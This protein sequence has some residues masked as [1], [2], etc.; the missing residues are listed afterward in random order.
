MKRVLLTGATGFIG[1]HCLPLL[2]EKG[3]EVYAVTSKL[4]VV[5]DDPR[6]HW[7]SS[8]L[9][10][11]GGVARL[12]RENSY[13]HLLHFAWFV[14]PG[15]C[16]TS[17][18]NFRWVETSLQLLRTFTEKGGR[19]AVF[20]GSCA[21]YDWRYG[22]CSER[23]TPLKPLSTYGICKK[24]LQEMFTE[25]TG[26]TGMS[27]AWGRIFFLYGPFEDSSRLV[28][29]VIF[30]LLQKKPA[31]CSHCRQIRD[32]MYVLDVA[33]AFVHLLDCDAQGEINIC[34]GKPLILKELVEKIAVELGGR[35][36]LRIGALPG[37]SDEPPL[38][39]GDAGRLESEV[40]FVPAYDL[41]DGIRETIAWWREAVKK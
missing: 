32:Y 24:A 20:A 28:A 11:E 14:V 18:E 35:D 9:L 27:A 26:K 13:S 1:R 3:F 17:L 2:L 31:L 37:S 15:E 5:S 34:S 10:E 21:E 12:F 6:V 16:Y 30:S 23:L 25:F 36:L 8:N 7:I 40:G 38:L 29:S 33:A 41:D 4:P 39:I 22:F 19:R